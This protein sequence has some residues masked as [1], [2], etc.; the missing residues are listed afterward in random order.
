MD[1]LILSNKKEKLFLENL[2]PA[3]DIYS[4]PKTKN[5]QEFRNTV[6]YRNHERSWALDELTR[7]IEDNLLL[8]IEKSARIGYLNR[9]LFKIANLQTIQE[10]RIES[11]LGQSEEGNFHFELTYPDL[12]QISFAVPVQLI[13]NSIK[14]GLFYLAILR[15][16]ISKQISIENKEHSF[17]EVQIDFINDLLIQCLFAMQRDSKIL[18]LLKQDC[19]PNEKRED[20][21]TAYIYSKME[22]VKN[23]RCAFQPHVG[24]S[25]TEKTEGIAD[26]SISDNSGKPFALCE[27]F[28]QEFLSKENIKQHLKKMFHYNSQRLNTWYVLIYYEGDFKKFHSAYSDYIGFVKTG[29]DFNYHLESIEDITE[30]FSNIKSQGIKIAQASHFWDS[31]KNILTTCYHFFVDISG[32]YGDNNC[33]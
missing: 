22:V 5:A 21:R 9:L 4:Y 18:K 32:T 23:L 1:N 29:I 26:F 7:E 3:E 2:I 10:E 27:A 17:S 12:T 13:L 24:S 6:T 25:A 11:M 15:I 19:Q 8:L 31:Q 30:N 33:D 28:N 20:K 14:A 16:F